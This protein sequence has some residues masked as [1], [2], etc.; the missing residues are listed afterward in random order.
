LV[1]CKLYDIGGF[2]NAV[3]QKLSL[4][5]NDSNVGATGIYALKNCSMLKASSD[6]D[7]TG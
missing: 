4:E 5:L 6:N 3:D 1:K 7:R 2:I